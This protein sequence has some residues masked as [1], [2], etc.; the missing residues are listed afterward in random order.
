MSTI[1]SVIANAVISNLLR[2]TEKLNTSVLNLSSGIRSNADVADFAVG[3]VLANQASSLRTSNLNAGQGKSLLATAKG[4]LEQILD[5]LQQQKDL[6]TKAADTSLTTNELANLNTE[7]TALTTE[8]DR[9]AS[10]TNFNNKNLLDGTI[11]G[12]ETVTSVTGQATENYTL[13][14]ETQVSFS[15]TVATGELL[16]AST[17][18]AVTTNEIGKT[19]GTVLLDLTGVGAGPVNS[20]VITIGGVGITFGTGETTAATVADAF[21]AAAEASTS[22]VIRNYTFTDLGTGGITVTGADLG[23]GSV[24]TVT[25]ALTTQGGIAANQVQLGTENIDTVGS[26]NAL[27]ITTATGGT[28]GTVRSVSASDLTVDEGLLGGF[29]KFTAALDTTGTQNRTTFTVDINGTTYT[30]QAVTLF[31]TGGFNSQGNTI[32]NGQVV[33]F[34]NTAGPTDSSN[35]YTDNGFTLTVGA[36]DITITGGTQTAFETDLTNT[37]TGFQTQ[38]TANRINQSRDVI[39]SEVNATGGDFDVSAAIGTTF[40]GIEGFDA[41]GTNARG[42][43]AFVGD[44]FGDDGRLGAIGSFAFNASTN[45]ITVTID[46]EVYTSDI[47]DNTASTGGIV[48]G[49]GNYNTTTKN[50]TVGAGTILVLHSAATTDGRQLRIDLSN[51]T[52][53]TI[54][55]TTSTTQKVF[56]DDLDT[57][58]GVS[59]NPALSFQVG[60]GATNTIGVS[61]GSAATTD[62]YLSDSGN[63]KT[64]SISTLAGATEASDVLDNAIN[65]VL[66]KIATVSAGLTSFDSAIVNNNVMIQNFEASSAS[67]L[68]TDYALESSRYA[69]LTLQANASISILA[70]NQ[71]RLDNLLQ[72][73][74]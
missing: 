14:D 10:T 3:S 65:S 53:T 29:S 6:A 67:L 17:F 45:K 25:F 49:A 46:N 51:L 50:L 40:A 1:Q 73:L 27:S 60:A 19:A 43:I 55:L 66:G 56:T 74:S 9:L 18:D 21:I 20:A 57:L 38:L 12:G 42:D 8:I 13:I 69:Q 48:D 52:D 22:S 34:Y 70:Q 28:I 4:G 63:S 26:G 61:L 37:A 23:T 44:T 47:S 62:I 39:L 16:T 11:S 32:K 31:G 71:K 24:D 35:E 54:E 72:L 59:G 36:T 15:G 2:T 7:F 41:E 33:T 64:L 30:S 68:G 5:L 58:F